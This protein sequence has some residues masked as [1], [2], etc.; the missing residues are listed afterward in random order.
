MI[1][2]ERTFIIDEGAMR[3]PLV[4][5]DMSGITSIDHLHEVL[6]EVLDFPGWYGR[7][8]DAFWDSIT[9][10]VEMPEH[11]QLIGWRQFAE[12]FPRDAGIKK[13]C[14][15]DM[16]NELPTLAALVEYS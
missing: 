4:T 15:D 16:S 14:L 10:L 1:G 2:Q 7:N 11:L 3:K 13:K 8:W 6:Y 9:A 5:V 12:R